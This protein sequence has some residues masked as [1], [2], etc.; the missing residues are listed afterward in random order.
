MGA[1]EKHNARAQCLRLE[2]GNLEALSGEDG[3][4]VNCRAELQDG[5]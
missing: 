3:R 2:K 1:R 5:W 4:E